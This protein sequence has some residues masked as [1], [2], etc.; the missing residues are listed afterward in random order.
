MDTIFAAIPAAIAVS[1]LAAR[2]SWRMWAP[3]RHLLA[4]NYAEARESAENLEKSWMRVIPGVRTSARY[5]IASA[6]HLNGE[7]QASLDAAAAIPRPH[8]ADTLDAASCVLLDRMPERVAELK[9]ERGEDLML[10]ALAL[11]SLG[12]PDQALIAE[13]E[14]TKPTSGDAVTIYEYLRGLYELRA[15]GKPD[16]HY[17]IA[18]DAPHA[19][20]YSKRARAYFE[21][22]PVEEGPSSLAPQVVA[23]PAI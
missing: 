8:D 10:K 17:R 21:P 12:K 19:N 20:V 23:K 3:A 4:G 11:Q 14:R 5:A 18:A 15:G 13:A 9:A 6:L 2:E 22:P 1:F 16:A 7:L